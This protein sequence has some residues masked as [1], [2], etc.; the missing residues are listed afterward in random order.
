M[1]KVDINGRSIYYDGYLLN[2]LQ[3]AKE[4]IQKDWDMV[5]IIDGIE[6]SGK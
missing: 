6:G 4:V 2:N 1:V 3:T 5:F